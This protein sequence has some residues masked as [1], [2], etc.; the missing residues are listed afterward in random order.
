MMLA[1]ITYQSQNIQ[2]DAILWDKDGT[3]LDF[4]QLW[5]SWAELLLGHMEGYLQ[6]RGHS[7]TGSR[8]K[9]MGT[10]YDA[11]GKLTG[12]DPRGPMAMASVQETTAVLAWQLY[13]AGVPWDEA[14]LQITDFSRQAMEQ[15]EQ[16]R[17]VQPLPNLIP[18]L[19][20]CREA[21]LPLAVVTSDWTSEALKHLR[22]SGLETYFTEIIGSDLVTSGKPAPDMALLACQRLSVQPGHTI[23]IGDSNADMQMGRQ[24]ELACC[25]GIA[26]TAEAPTHLPDAD[27]IIHDYR[28]L[29]IITADGSQ[30]VQE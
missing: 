26:P 1:L 28:E 7:F 18:L 15:M 17:P 16:T 24:A 13:S 19:N 2:C 10:I 5:G 20:S 14:I 11:S 30:S 4:M 21:G 29:Q 23:L 3:L 9:V 27:I 12:Y 8:E 25:I 22:W 6:D